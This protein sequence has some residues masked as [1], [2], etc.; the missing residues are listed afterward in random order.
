MAAS[1][2]FKRVVKLT[3]GVILLVLGFIGLFL[4]ILQGILLIMGGLA[5]LSTESP[6]V[7]AFNFRARSWLRKK[8]RAQPTVEGSSDE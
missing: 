7:R 8:L 3:A 5:L 2:H 6:R 1:R 4:P